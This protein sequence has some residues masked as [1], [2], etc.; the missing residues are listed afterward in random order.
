MIGRLHSLDSSYNR[1]PRVRNWSDATEGLVRITW[2]I[3]SVHKDFEMERE[4][5]SGESILLRITHY[6]A[7]ALLPLTPN[8]VSPFYRLFSHPTDTL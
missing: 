2:L 1:F 7:D 6:G 5:A 8:V 4:Y 3:R